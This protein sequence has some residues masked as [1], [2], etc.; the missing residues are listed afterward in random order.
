MKGITHF[1]VGVAV[2]SCVPGAVQAG[3]DG[4]PLYFI[5]G[6][7]FGLLPDTLDSKFYR[8][9]YR[10]DMEVMP[11]PKDADPAMVAQGVAYAAEWC[12]RRRAPVRIKLNTV[13]LGA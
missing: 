5:L 13:R 1:A 3:V 8:F 4:N 11:D 2:A 6:G 10:R 7:V 12:A 9:L